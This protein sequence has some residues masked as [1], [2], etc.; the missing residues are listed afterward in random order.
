MRYKDM[1]QCITI[2]KNREE[3]QSDLVVKPVDIFMNED[4]SV[5]IPTLSPASIPMTAWAHNQMSKK[6]DIPT[7]YYNRMLESD[8]PLLSNN[9]NRW[10]QDAN[11]LMIRTESGTARA[12]LSSKYKVV[13]NRLVLLTVLNTLTD[14][15]RP[16][17]TRSLSESDT[18]FYAKF[19][20]QETYDMGKG[21]L[22]RGGIV[23]RN[24]EVG[25]S[26]LQVDFFT[27][28]LSCG[29]DAIF[30]GE[31]IS[32]VHIGRKLDAG[33]IDYA[34]DTVEADNVAMMKAI[35]DIVHTAFDPA[36]IQVIYDRVK[37]SKENVISETAQ[38]IRQIQAQHKL[39]DQL[40][41]RLLVSLQ[42]NT[43]FDVAQTLTL[44][45][46]YITNEDKRIEMEELGGELLIM[47][48]TTFN[49]AFKVNGKELRIA[50]PDENIDMSEFA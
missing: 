49:T 24:S 16:F 29:N 46:Q 26:R 41:D 39:S 23:I 31:G 3:K 32:K 19:V 27:C 42:G 7:G 2:L 35:R 38:V 34:S 14:M 12:V 28:R 22:H 1:Q 17:I 25:A 18:T 33:L 15:H 47:P 44:N 6:L 9:V 11:S 30:G 4:A 45:A 36:G 10:L 20:G 50:A 43:Q 37:L 21:D 13:Q 48:K 8:K 40:T 5:E